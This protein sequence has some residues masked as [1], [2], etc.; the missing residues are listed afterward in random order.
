MSFVNLV[1]TA[2]KGMISNKLRAGLTALG[3]MIGVASVIVTL[4]LGN[5]AREAV[6]ASFRFLGSDQLQISAKM[7]FSEGEIKESG[8]KLTYSEVLNMPEAAPLVKQVDISVGLTG[9][10]RRKRN[11]LD[12]GISGVTAD[13]LAN[14]ISQGEVQ[15]VDWPDGKPLNAEAF[16]SQGRNFLPGEILQNAPVCLLGY[17]TAQ[18][19]FAGEDPLGQTVWINRKA[20]TVMGVMAELEVTDPAMRQYSKP[21]EGVFLPVGVVINDMYEE[22]PSVSA[23]VRIS[24]PQR[25]N[26][27]R[28][29]ITEYLRTRHAIMPNEDGTYPDDFSLTSKQDLLGAQQEAARTFSILLTAMAVVSLSVGGIGIMNVMLVS[30]TERTREIGVRLA[31]GARSRDI[32]LQFLLEAVLLSAASGVMGAAL[33]VLAIPLA[34]TLNNGVALLAPESIPLA[35]GVALATGVGFGIY[36]ALRAARLNPIEALGYE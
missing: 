31:V 35:F 24:D 25:M 21:N 30:V 17:Q 9:K 11:V 4:A 1:W 28:Q 27:A 3:V 22:E 14:Q 18:D 32:V 36:P 12:L 26:E 19:L 8:K 2:W 15:P 23:M 7:D 20:Y 33:G 10:V 34:A 29:Q 6:D 5:G 13:A 16:L